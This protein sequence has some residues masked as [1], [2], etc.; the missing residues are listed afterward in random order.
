MPTQ[1]DVGTAAVRLVPDDAMPTPMADAVLKSITHGFN[2]TDSILQASTNSIG[3]KIDEYYDYARDEYIN[4][5]PHSYRTTA[6]YLS[7]PD[8]AFQTVLSA[9]EGEQ[10]IIVERLAGE[11]ATSDEEAWAYLHQFHKYNPL[12]SSCDS[13]SLDIAAEYTVTFVQSR[14][15]SND[16]VE[17]TFQSSQLVNDSPVIFTR[18]F[19][20]R[21]N[22]RGYA[23]NVITYTLPSSSHARVFHWIYYVDTLEFPELGTVTYEAENYDFYPIAPIRLNKV[24]I[25]EDTYVPHYVGMG[26]VQA[27]P[28]ALN[29]QTGKLLTILGV[30]RDDLTEQITSSPD[31][32]DVSDA[33]LMFGLHVADDSP[34]AVEY[35]FNMWTYQGGLPFHVATD[36]TKTS[37]D[38]W[39]TDNFP[40]GM[41]DGRHSIRISDN[42]SYQRRAAEYRQDIS[43]N[44]INVRTG[45]VG[46]HGAIGTYSQEVT[47]R[48]DVRTNIPTSSMYFRL[49]TSAT[50]YDE[51]EVHGLQSGNGIGTGG[52]GSETDSYI[53]YLADAVNGVSGA[54]SFLI[55][56]SKTI[57]DMSNSQVA[58]IT[59]LRSL[60]LFINAVVRTKLAWYETVAFAEWMKIIGIVIAIVTFSP[61]I[62]AIF[63]AGSLY[64]AALLVVEF[65][66]D[67]L[68]MD[69]LGKGLVFLVEKIGGEAA[70]IVATIVAAVAVAY[71]LNLNIDSLALAQDLLQGVTMITDAI[72]EVTADEFAQLEQEMED[73]TSDAT[74]KEEELQEAYD[75][76]NT[77]S[78]LE[79]Y[80]LVSTAPIIPDETT[81]EYF[82]RTIHSGNVG[83]LSLDMPNNYVDMALTLPK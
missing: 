45:L 57:L 1:I 59:V 83:V 41:S 72:Q 35:F 76:L 68:I 12:D 11:P 40:G 71:G 63:N 16:D 82:H 77:G 13:L 43:Y 15:T 34:E 7:V 53:V 44:Y 32:D 21:T 8:S 61:Q 25:N 73:F 55:P 22:D 36:W 29:E 67:V 65:T 20:L 31:I 27:E 46:N 62:S 79:W 24:N 39:V 78:N 38:Q 5:L 37:Y 47:L 80:D 58:N 23:A 3:N 19:V 54:A 49:Q 30:N 50:T 60:H 10:V 75:M 81:D 51:V 66:L 33:F 2:I 26:P 70:L 48:D 64:A 18:E 56:V 4:G 6:A 69:L 28:T 42:G 14:F 74:E 52:A 9:I 17:V